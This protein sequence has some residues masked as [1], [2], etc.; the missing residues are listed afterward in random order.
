MPETKWTAFIWPPDRQTNHRNTRRQTEFVSG[1][2]DHI[3]ALPI[4][5]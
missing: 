4:M 3:V 5:L 1:V 2:V